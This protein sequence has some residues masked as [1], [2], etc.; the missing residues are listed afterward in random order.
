MNTPTKADTSTYYIYILELDNGS[1]Y[2]GVTKYLF[3]RWKEH[4]SGKRGARYTRAHKPVRIVQGWRFAGTTGQALKIESLIKRKT[5][6]FK[7][8]IVQ[9]PIL[10][11]SVVRQVVCEAIVLQP[12]SPEILDKVVNDADSSD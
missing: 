7:E 8:Q 3:R 12:V 5:R 10:L 4:V 11:Q 9:S 6:S 1:F 2:T